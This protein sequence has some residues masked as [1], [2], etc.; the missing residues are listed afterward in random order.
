[1]HEICWF[2]VNKKA[3]SHLTTLA[4]HLCA[5]RLFQQLPLIPFRTTRPTNR[6]LLL[7]NWMKDKGT[8]WSLS[9]D[10][11]AYR[12]GAGVF[13]RNWKLA[14]APTGLAECARATG[15]E[16]CVCV[17]V[18]GVCMHMTMRLI[19]Y[20]MYGEGVCE[21]GQLAECFVPKFLLA[22][23]LLWREHSP[24]WVLPARTMK[25]DECV[26]C[27]LFGSDC[28]QTKRTKRLG[29]R[30][31]DM[32]PPSKAL[33]WPGYLLWWSYVFLLAFSPLPALTKEC[34]QVDDD[35]FLPN[36]CQWDNMSLELNCS[37]LGLTRVPYVPPCVSGVMRQ[38]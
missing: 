8:L 30:S 6:W 31:S 36:G 33:R 3:L 1:M 19:D 16:G 15:L 20:G 38:L 23:F 2:L 11:P 4:R 7:W 12:P 25:V 13:T 29:T 18:R 28:A 35:G 9:I 37:S 14:H 27:R 5:P 24:L 32:V 17:Y 21:A 26:S 10:R 22:G 34:P